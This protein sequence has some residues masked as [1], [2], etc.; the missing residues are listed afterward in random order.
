M[1]A[2]FFLYSIKNINR[3]IFVMEGTVLLVRYRLN[4]Y[5]LLT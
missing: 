5:M 4:P 1:T 3:F 2:I